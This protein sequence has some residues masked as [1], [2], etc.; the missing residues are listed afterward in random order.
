MKECPHSER[1][2]EN[3]MVSHWHVT[4]QVANVGTSTTFNDAQILTT[5]ELLLTIFWGAQLFVVL[6]HMRGFS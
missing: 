6:K 1:A 3:S 5:F 4:L 2:I